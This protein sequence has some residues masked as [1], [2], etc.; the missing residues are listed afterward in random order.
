M[1]LF[2]F[3]DLAGPQRPAMV[4][5]IAF[6]VIDSTFSAMPLGIAYLAAGAA[7]GDPRAQSMLP[8]PVDTAGGILGIAGLLLACYALQWL[9][10]LLSSDQ[11]YGASYRMTS[12]LRS[13][14]ADHLRT[15]PMSYFARQAPGRLGHVVMQDVLAIEQGTG[16]SRRPAAGDP[17]APPRASLAARRHRGA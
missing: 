17:C 6:K 1:M 10:F 9:F 11:G 5:A 3:L 13:E 4:R 7:L 14:L 15:L 12:R 8:F 16:N 2:E